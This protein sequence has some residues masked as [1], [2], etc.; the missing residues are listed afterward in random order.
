MAKARKQ[1]AAAPLTAHIRR[2]I[3]TETNLRVLKALPAFRA[4]HDLPKKLRHLLEKLANAERE[5]T[6]R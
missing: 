2:E 4:E 5:P 1:Q 3:A 6:R